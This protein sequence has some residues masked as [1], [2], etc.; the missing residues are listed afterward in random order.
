MQALAV[1]G[2]MPRLAVQGQM[3]DLRRLYAK[4]PR[5]PYARLPDSLPRL[6]VKQRSRHGKLPRLMPE[7]LMP[8]SP[9]ML[10]AMPKTPSPLLMYAMLKMP[11][12]VPLAPMCVKPET[13]MPDSLV[14]VYAMPGK[15]LPG[16]PLLQPW[17]PGPHVPPLQTPPAPLRLMQPQRPIQVPGLPTPRVPIAAVP[18]GCPLQGRLAPSLLTAAGL[19]LRAPSGFCGTA[20]PLP[21]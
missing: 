13:L 17:M 3:P 14:L 20:V 10:H 1:P 6:H 11:T 16:S 15:L 21:Q 7:A 2:R 8:D 4:L 9:P 5:L 12:P 19:R 18:P